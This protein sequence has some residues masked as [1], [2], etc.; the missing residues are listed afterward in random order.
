MRE[1]T[2]S[3]TPPKPSR[4]R[5]HNTE[6]ENKT[7]EQVEAQARGSLALFA[8]KNWWLPRSK[9]VMKEI[10]RALVV[11]GIMSSEHF[12]EHWI[13]HTSATLSNTSYTL[14]QHKNQLP[15]SISFFAH[16][17]KLK[18]CDV[19]LCE[20]KWHKIRPRGLF[21]KV[22]DTVLT[23]KFRLRTTAREA[24][25]NQRNTFSSR[26]AHNFALKSW[27]WGRT[28]RLRWAGVVCRL[29][30]FKNSQQTTCLSLAVDNP[31]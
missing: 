17:I 31:E 29:R 5:S 16:R 9:E 2:K 15:S 12:F 8:Y 6:K 27:K 30:D 1:R 21:S 18:S 13:K 14:P 24:K 22:K 7:K 19:K 23:P 28:D 26:H 20:K 3:L 25:Q 10:Q 4:H 11:F